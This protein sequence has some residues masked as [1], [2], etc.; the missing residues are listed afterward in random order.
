L[1]FVRHSF[2]CH[3]FVKL[4]DDGLDLYCSWPY[5]SAYLGRQSLEATEQYVRL[6]AQLYPELLKDADRL[7]VDILP[8]INNKQNQK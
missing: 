8:N 7:Y 3:S 4:A 2:A 6:T 5:L 1:D